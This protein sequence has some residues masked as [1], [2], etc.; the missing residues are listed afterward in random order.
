[1]CLAF[2]ISA[3]SGGVRVKKDALPLPPME[4]EFK[5][6][7][8]MRMTEGVKTPTDIE[9][10]VARLEKGGEEIE[11]CGSTKISIITI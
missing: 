5:I 9:R 3:S 1:M 11:L 6:W 7:P 10:N 4:K 8:M 2:K